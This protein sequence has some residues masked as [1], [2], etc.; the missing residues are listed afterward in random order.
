MGSAIYGQPGWRFCQLDVH[1]PA[2]AHRCRRRSDEPSAVSNG[3]EHLHSRL[4]GYRATLVEI[5]AVNR[6]LILP[7]LGARA[8][9]LGAIELASRTCTEHPPSGILS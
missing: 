2:S 6:Y 5:E 7:E 1:P 9:V 4:S 8:G 3:C